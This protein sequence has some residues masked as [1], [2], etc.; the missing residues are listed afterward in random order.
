M[1]THSITVTEADFADAVLTRS[2]SVPVM[3]DFWAPWCGPCRVLGPALEALAAEAGGRFVLAKIDT[4]QNPTLAQRY[5]IRGIPAVK[6]F[7]DGAVAAEFVGALP[8]VELRAFIDRYVP[9]STVEAA[10]RAIDLI[11]AADF[12]GAD[13]ALPAGSGGPPIVAATRARIALLLGRIAEA[14]AAAET[15][16][17][18]ADERELA[19]AVLDAVSLAE[20]KGPAESPADE[21]YLRAGAAVAAGQLHPA[22]DA[23]LEVVRRDRKLRDDGGRKRLLALFQI[24]GVR[25]ELSDDYRRKLADAL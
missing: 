12:V 7:R 15:V 18:L 20:E 25:S 8:A 24:A 10:R 21:H 1:T 4:D 6:L 5:D 11:A 23:L 17:A 22:L 13:V 14:R 2:R 16:P 9:D 19:D 3:V